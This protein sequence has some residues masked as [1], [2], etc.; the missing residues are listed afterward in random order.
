MATAGFPSD[1][2]VT[3]INDSTEGTLISAGQHKQQ[4][5]TLE[6]RDQYVL[7]FLSKFDALPIGTILPTT[8]DYDLTAEGMPNGWIW[9]NGHSCNAAQFPKLWAKI[10][11]IALTIDEYKAKMRTEEGIQ[12]PGDP[13]SETPCG[14]YVIVHGTRTTQDLND[15]D[16]CVPNLRNVFI[17]SSTMYSNLDAKIGQFELDSI[18]TH[19]HNVAAYPVNG[20]NLN[21]PITDIGVALTDKIDQKY[22]NM[23]SN[24]LVLTNTTDSFASTETKPKSIALKFMLKADFTSFVTDT[25][26]ETTANNVNG[27]IPSERPPAEG[28]PG[29]KLF[30]IADHETG[31]IR[32]DWFDSTGLSQAVVESSRDAIIDIASTIAVD[33][34]RLSQTSRADSI[35]LSDANGKIN[36]N[37]LTLVTD[38]QINALFPNL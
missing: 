33:V 1:L 36:V 37:Y 20:A 4:I 6:A 26:V 38:D 17:K 32:L 19:T 22:N 29:E 7:D 18:K 15:I 30:P 10:K 3:G 31:K 27:Y 24:N 25:N 12:N 8:I 34:D 2:K 21:S 28:N 11:D 23:S 9:A 16:F 13:D 14:Y 35:P 5:K